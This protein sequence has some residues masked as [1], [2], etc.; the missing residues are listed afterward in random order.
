MYWH[1]LSA[2]QHI[3]AEWRGILWH[4]CVEYTYVSFCTPTTAD[5]S[6]ERRTEQ[7]WSNDQENPQMY[8][9][10]W[11]Y[12][13]WIRQGHS[14]GNLFRSNFNEMQ[15]SLSLTFTNLV[16]KGTQYRN[17]WRII[18]YIVSLI[19]SWGILTGVPFQY[20]S[21]SVILLT[22]SMNVRYHDIIL[23]VITV[24]HYILH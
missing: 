21:F 17:V 7:F 18:A 23:H 22:I 9:Q 5:G 19:S 16:V 4:I 1:I 3:E 13:D 2:I 15:R 24:Y 12:A 11:L 20:L 14:V 10:V 8:S 6:I